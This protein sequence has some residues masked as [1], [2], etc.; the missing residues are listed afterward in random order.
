LHLNA[1]ELKSPF[2]E[3]DNET[4]K[5]VESLR[6]AP[7]FPYKNIFQIFSSIINFEKSIYNIKNT[8]TRTRT[9]LFWNGERS[10]KARSS[11]KSH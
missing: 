6:D 2:K 7:I 9:N 4:P 5:N 3:S 10:R 11:L 1:E 8:R